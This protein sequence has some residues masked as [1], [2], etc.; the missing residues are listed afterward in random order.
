MRM[1]PDLLNAAAF[2][3]LTMMVAK[4]LFPSHQAGFFALTDTQRYLVNETAMNLITQAR[5]QIES[6]TFAGRF[7]LPAPVA[8]APM[9][10]GQSPA[11]E[12][13]LESSS[14]AVGQGPGGPMPTGQ[15]L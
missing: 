5:W 6:A 2:A 4:E 14:P 9:D 7:T 13:K 12:T 15:Y 10:G 1:T 8:L 3:Q 11:A